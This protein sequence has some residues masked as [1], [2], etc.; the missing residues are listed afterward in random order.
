M[1]VDKVFLNRSFHCGSEETNLTS[2]H[3]DVGSIPGLAQWVKDL[4]CELWCRLQMQLGSGIAL[5]AVQVVQAGGYSSNSTPSLGIS[6]CHGSGPKKTK[7][8]KQKT[9]TNKQTKK[10]QNL[11]KQDTKSTHQKGNNV[12]TGLLK[13][14]FKIKKFFF[15]LAAH[16]AYGS[17]QARNQIQA[18]ASLGQGLTAQRQAGSLTHCTT[19]GTPKIKNFHSSSITFRE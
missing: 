15:F 9:K 12:V 11:L 14:K 2:I 4:S 1:Y 10:T 17:S 19:E 16:A 5:A 7:T 18:G 13:P 6:K 3:G 8:K